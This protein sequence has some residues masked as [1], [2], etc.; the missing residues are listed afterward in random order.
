MGHLTDNTRAFFVTGTDT[1]IGKTFVCKGLLQALNDKGYSTAGYKPIAAGCDNTPGGLRNEDALTLQANSSLKLSYDEV[2]PIAFEAPIAPHLALKQTVKEG[3]VHY[4]PIDKIREGFIHLL[5]KEPNVI[6][7]EGAG[8]WR[9][10]L[11]G[12]YQGRPRYLSE[13]VSELNL[14]VI[15]VVGMRL[16][17]LNHAVLT[18]EAIRNDGLKIAGWVANQVD[19]DMPLVDENIDSLQ[20]LI[21]APF[22]GRVPA[23]KGKEQAGQYLNLAGLDL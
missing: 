23:L 6:V 21:N 20:S 13:F 15:L 2:N 5:Q 1:E 16:G 17:C 4:I 10:P 3:E 12:S 14:S 9:L 19:A 18:A 7:I 11:G 8:G 22:L